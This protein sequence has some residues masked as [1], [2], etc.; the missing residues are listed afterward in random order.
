MLNPSISI[1]G[2]DGI[3]AFKSIPI[4]S[5]ADNIPLITLITKLAA[6]IAKFKAVT[7]ASIITPTVL[8]KTSNN[9]ST[10][11]NSVFLEALETGIL[12]SSKFLPNLNLLLSVII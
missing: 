2:I 10:A 1:V 9:D 6:S 4:N 7:N 3:F 12:I 5:R 8:K 11:D